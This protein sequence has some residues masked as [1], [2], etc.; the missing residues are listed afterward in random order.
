MSSDIRTWFPEG[1]PSPPS[2]LSTNVLLDVHLYCPFSCVKIQWGKLDCHKLCQNISV[3]DYF[4]RTE[5]M[6]L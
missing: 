6:K 1:V 5:Y 2:F 4:L 3:L